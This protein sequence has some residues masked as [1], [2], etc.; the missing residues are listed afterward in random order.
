V[1]YQ[2]S[3][4]Q[5]NSS[6]VERDYSSDASM[7]HRHC[8]NDTK[9]FDDRLYQTAVEICSSTDCISKYRLKDGS[10]DCVRSVDEASDVSSSC[11]SIAMYR[12]HC[13]EEDTCLLVGQISSHSA[14]GN[15]TNNH[16]HGLAF[17]FVQCRDRHDPN[18]QMLRDFIAQSTVRPNI[19]RDSLMTSD[20]WNL[21]F[22]QYC[23]TFFNHR[24][25]LDEDSSFCQHW[26]CPKDHYQCSS[27]QCIPPQWICD[28]K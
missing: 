8:W 19:T 12:F 11:Q 27:G 14:P 26:I 28:G 13:F 3:F 15:C 1:Y 21:P 5:G 4:C 16:Y 10:R 25:R 2:W 22:H 20:Q 7:F 9:T 6:D 18:C 17:R 23:N 24:S